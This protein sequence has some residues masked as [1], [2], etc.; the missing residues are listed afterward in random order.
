[1][2]QIRHEAKGY[3]DNYC[4][5][6]QKENA[7]HKRFIET[8][9]LILGPK[10]DLCEYLKAVSEDSREML[11]ML[12]DFLAENYVKDKAS[13]CEE[14]ID[15][16]KIDCALDRFWNKATDNIRLLKRSSDLMSSLRMNLFKKVQ[17]V[18]RILCNYVFL[19]RSSVSIQDDPA[20]TVY[21][22][23]REPLLEK[24][25]HAVESLSPAASDGSSAMGEEGVMGKMAATS[26]K[27]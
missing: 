25:W 17:K 18:V 14:N 24:I 27:G 8:Y 5:G 7:S 6:F 21:K 12:E 20:S 15:P 10:S 2:D 19:C 4:S 22:K 9:K 11:E 3:L 23:H 16:S 26:V 1:M 13:I